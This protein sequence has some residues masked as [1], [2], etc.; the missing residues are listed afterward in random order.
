M[1]FARYLVAISLA[2]Q[3]VPSAWAGRRPDV[4]LN[5]EST[6]LA[7]D[8]TVRPSV[9]FNG[10]SPGPVLRF[11]E[12]DHVFIRVFNRL[13]TNTTVHYHGLSQFASPFADGTPQTSQW[14]IAPG[15]YFDYEFLL[16]KGSAG[17]YMYHTHVGF[18]I[19]TAYGAFIVE[20][21]YYPPFRYDA[22]LP[23]L[24]GDF[25][26]KESQPILDGLLG[27]PLAWLGEPQSLTVNGNALGNCT[28][29]N[30]TN[31]C[32]HHVLEV[33]AGKTYRVRAIGITALTYLYI[34]IEGHANLSLIEADGAYIKPT[35][36]S[37]LQLASGQRFSFLLKTK[38]E[39]ELAALGKRTFWGSI[40]SRYRP[41]RDNGTFVLSYKPRRGN[42]DPSVG[43]V[44]R[45]EGLT[46]QIVLPGEDV[47][48]V[49]S[50]FKPYS[51]DERPP[52][53]SEVAR[54][55]T[56]GGQQI[57]N[58][59]KYTKW[60][61]NNVTY[62]EEAPS[63]PYLVQAYK[64]PSEYKP[65]Y[66]LAEQNKGYDASTNTYPVRLGETVDILFENLA[67]TSNKTEAHPWHIH[68]Q[69]PW[70]IA[71]GI[72]A[73]SEAALANASSSPYTPAKPIKRDTVV[74]FPGQGASFGPTTAP[75]GTETAWMMFRLKADNP[76]AWLVHCHIQPHA[77][78]G[79]AFV[80]TVGMDKLPILP[81]GFANSYF[82]YNPTPP[83]TPRSYFEAIG[84]V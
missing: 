38:T 74:I 28:T 21:P 65:N 40:E 41:I 36:A 7:S 5:V 1:G 60:Y 12:G 35:T 83:A 8:C 66:T 70:Y 39:S 62:S 82:E 46:S 33:E 31:T 78:M 52:A 34:A 19:V 45:P 3:L 22:D 69:H 61:A 44:P 29:G 59:A 72:G 67:S 73:F 81:P 68:G 77:Q 24:F 63:T 30:C 84:R 50:Q 37:H 51:N 56:I 80:L 13:N 16:E 6:A 76:G 2:L 32:H 11:K 55:I 10:T 71:G 48:W 17:T 79:M 75:N 58:A 49:D 64:T 25:Y 23:V 53:A 47:A 9:T 27:A 26:H 54:R 14:P 20:D 4:I 43:K 15:S 42:S 18:D 57:L